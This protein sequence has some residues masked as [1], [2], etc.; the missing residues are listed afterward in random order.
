MKFNKKIIITILTL[1]VLLILVGIGGYF[2]NKKVKYLR[3]QP[4]SAECL[5]LGEKKLNEC[6][7]YCRTEL[8]QYKTLVKNYKAC[9]DTCNSA[10]SVGD[11]SQVKN[12]QA[13]LNS[14]TDEYLKN[15]AQQA[16]KNCDNDCFNQ[17]NA[18]VNECKTK[19]IKF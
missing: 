5:A 12:L 3:S 11:D 4:P 15:E 18:L 9:Q 2:Y 14:C 1:S 7:R 16:I 17:A 10:Y 6:T 19:I 8:P 13:C